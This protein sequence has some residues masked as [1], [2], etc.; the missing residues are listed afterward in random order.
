MAIN[1]RNIRILDSFLTMVMNNEERKKQIF[2][3]DL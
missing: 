2:G 1:R 3:S